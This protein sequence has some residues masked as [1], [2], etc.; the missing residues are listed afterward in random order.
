[1]HEASGNRFLRVRAHAGP[2]RLNYRATVDRRS[3]APN[4]NAL[5]VP[6]HAIPD[7]LMRF[8]LPTRCCESDLLA[9]VAQQSFA[10]SPIGHARVQAICDWVRTHVAYRVGST[11]ATTTSV[12]VFVQR[13][14]VCRDFAHFDEPPPE[15]HAI[16]EAFIGGRWLLF[17][18]SGMAPVNQVVRLA[19]GRDA[20]DVAFATIYGPARM[21]AMSSVLSC[22]GTACADLTH[23]Q[24]LAP[25]MTRWL[26][27]LRGSATLKAPERMG[28]MLGV[29]LIAGCA[30]L[31]RVPPEASP[32]AVP[33]VPMAATV[34]VEP[35]AAAPVSPTQAKAA[36]HS[37]TA[38]KAAATPSKAPA[39][40]P[41]TPLAAAP[42]AKSETPA[43]ALAKPQA[44]AP[45]DLKSL[46]T[47]LKE[48]E[49][50]G[51]FTKLALKNQ[52]DD[53]LDRFRAFYQG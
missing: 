35:K 3:D 21:M 2:L 1:V 4:L 16:F 48:T 42:A 13:S 44:A 7:G 6:V 9:P 30:G 31:E 37:N 51:V 50:I 19:T 43:A 5:Q 27:L 39:K 38:A 32:Q 8:L 26:A 49:A 33:A 34:L 25:G 52:I 24:A 47:R 40:P 22:I 18:P 53:L 17:D 11:S 41:A 28:A 23:S 14:G 12:D 36:E 29:L 10:P 15:L 20:K 46:E 45:L